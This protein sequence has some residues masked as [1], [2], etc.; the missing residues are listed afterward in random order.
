M[1]VRRFRHAWQTPHGCANI[2]RV[3]V[4]DTFEGICDMWGSAERDARIHLGLEIMR[5]GSASNVTLCRFENISCVRCCLPH[6]GGDSHLED[7]EKRRLASCGATGPALRIGQTSRYLGPNALV[8]KF[9]NVNPLKDPGIEASQYEDSFQDVGREEMERRFTERRRLFLEIFDPVRPR[10]SLPRY[11][12]EAQQNEGYTY[13]PAVRTGPA[14]LFLGGSVG[15]GNQ[16]KGGLPECHLLGFVDGEGTAGCL[17]HPLAETSHGYDGRDRV[18]FFHHT[19]C[20]AN[21]QCQASVEFRHLSPAAFEV[22]GRTV[23][24]MSWYEYSR[25]ATSVL[26]YYLRSYDHVLQN[27]AARDVLS[28][29]TLEDLVAFTNALF[30]G[31]PLR[32]LERKAEPPD[33]NGSASMDPLEILSADIPLAERILYIALGSRFSRNHF[34]IGLERARA[35]IEKCTAAAAARMEQSPIHSHNSA[36]STL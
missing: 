22:F 17:A 24:G 3:C 34:T 20:C 14:S 33:R 16:E 19:G 15:T 18:G 27:L 25:H 6:I 31:W 29:W 26:V 36:D 12:K 5:S 9:R 28:A 2:H 30:D 1:A 8:M 35:H 13:T 21:V 7:S 4:P 32:E 11:M 10:Q 23:R